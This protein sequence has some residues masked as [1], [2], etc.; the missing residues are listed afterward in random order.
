MIERR[1]HERYEL[2]LQVAIEGSFDGEL[3]IQETQLENIGI[4]GA[5]FG[6]PDELEKGDELDMSLTDTDSQFANA[7]GLDTSTSG[8]L[9]FK[10][11]CKVLRQHKLETESLENLVAVQ[12]S[13]PLRIKILPKH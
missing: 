12:F 9:Q 6:I 2:P 4:G 1:Q 5:L 7:L 8:P 13:S 3:K 11:N 10:M